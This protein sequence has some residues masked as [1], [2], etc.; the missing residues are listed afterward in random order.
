MFAQVYAG[1][2]NVDQA[3]EKLD[4][5]AAQG[6]FLHLNRNPFLIPLYKD[7]RFAELG[8]RSNQTAPCP[9]P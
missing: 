4:E 3:F 9:T 1:L 8:R 2:G 5:A 6:R 7:P